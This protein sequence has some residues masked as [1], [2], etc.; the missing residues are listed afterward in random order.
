MKFLPEE[1]KKSR[2]NKLFLLV[3][4]G[5]LVCYLFLHNLMIPFVRN[6]G[7]SQFLLDGL[8]YYFFPQFILFIAFLYSDISKKKKSFIPIL[9]TLNFAILFFSAFFLLMNLKDGV[10][11][12]EFSISISIVAIFIFFIGF[13]LYFKKFF[14]WDFPQVY[15]HYILGLLLGLGLNFLINSD[16]IYSER[17]SV[18][19]KKKDFETKLES[20]KIHL[21]A[22]GFTDRNVIINF[23]GFKKKY[24]LYPQNSG[25]I[26]LNKTSNKYLIRLEYIKNKKWYFKKIISIGA[27]KKKN[28]LIEENGIY[29][30]YS[31]SS[32]DLGIYIIVMGSDL[33]DKGQYIIKRKGIEVKK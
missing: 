21:P 7:S 2:L 17:Q 14:L 24:G 25:I 15:S 29:R 32:K 12:K 28:I 26:I 20:I 9:V 19:I 8:Q 10:S 3:F 23:E 5:G 6:I 30:L 22:D 18:I 13:F 11:V 33:F 4:H 27:F 31:P 16:L 1:R